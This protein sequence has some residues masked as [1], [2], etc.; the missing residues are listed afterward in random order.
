MSDDQ[1]LKKEEIQKIPSKLMMLL[2]LSQFVGEGRASVDEKYKNVIK[3]NSF[4]SNTFSIGRDD[5]QMAPF[6]GIQDKMLPWFFEADWDHAYLC[7]NEGFL[8]LSS[9]NDLS[10]GIVFGIKIRK[11]RMSILW[12]QKVEGERQLR[13]KIFKMIT[14]SEYQISKKIYA[15]LGISMVKSIDEFMKGNEVVIKKDNNDDNDDFSSAEIW[16]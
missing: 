9:N 5:D 8:Y 4:L 2:R 13:M 1:V 15:T 3:L 14:K 11:K 12:P 16:E 6:L 7:I 10:Q